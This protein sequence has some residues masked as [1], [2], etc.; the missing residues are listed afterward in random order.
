MFVSFFSFDCIDHRSRLCTTTNQSCHIISFQC[1]QVVRSYEGAGHAA[2]LTTYS[3]RCVELLRVDCNVRTALVVLKDLMAT[4][5]NSATPLATTGSA[6]DPTTTPAAVST[7]SPELPSLSSPAIIDRVERQFHI[8]ELVM[9]NLEAVAARRRA[10]AASAASAS[11]VAAAVQ[12]GVAS[13]QAVTVVVDAAATAALGPAAEDLD[14]VYAYVDF[15]TYL[16][17]HGSP[18]DWPK[19]C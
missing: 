14:T 18:F 8:L 7:Q 13:Q 5:A 15:L 9:S 11:A 4:L 17:A 10:R 1:M 12:G 19:V 2:F 6:A 3:Q 16:A